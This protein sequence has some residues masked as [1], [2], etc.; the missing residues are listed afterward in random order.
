MI[1][2]GLTRLLSAAAATFFGA[3][4]VSADNVTGVSEVNARRLGALII[5]GDILIWNCP[6]CAGSV[7]MRAN[8]VAVGRDGNQRE[9]AV[10]ITRDIVIKSPKTFEALGNAPC[11]KPDNPNDYEEYE[12]EGDWTVDLTYT[13][14]QKDKG[15]SWSTLGSVVGVNNNPVPSITLSREA[16]ERIRACAAEIEKRKQTPVK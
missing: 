4:F 8:S 9:F 16:V 7:V 13:Y 5:P 11:A 6:T 12:P 10:R 1:R 2:N 3:A 15:Y 14:F